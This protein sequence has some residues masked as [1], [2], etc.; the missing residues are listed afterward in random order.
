MS[1]FTFE[2]RD[3]VVIA[4]DIGDGSQGPAGAQGPAGPSGDKNYVHDQ[5]SASAVWTV[6][7]G[8]GKYPSVTV[9]DSA[10]DECEGHV[11]HVT[12]NQTVI[13]FSAAFSGKAFFN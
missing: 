10:G 13:T 4:V 8:L 11:N 3:A 9:V 6:T 7:H 2:L 12:L 1:D 5:M